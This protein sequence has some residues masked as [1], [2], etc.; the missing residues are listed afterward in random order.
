MKIAL[1]LV[2]LAY[3]LLVFSATLWPSG[4]D[5]AVAKSAIGLWIFPPA[6]IDVILNVGMLAP[7]AFLARL[8][9]PRLPWWKWALLTCALSAGIELAQ[10]SVP[11]LQRRGTVINVLENGAGAWIGAWVGQWVRDLRARRVWAGRVSTSSPQR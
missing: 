5:V 1:R 11:G 8:S 10:W 9:F 2:T 3:L 6:V 7:L 4:D